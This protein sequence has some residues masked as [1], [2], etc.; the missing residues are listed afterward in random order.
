MTE[1]TQAQKEAGNYKMGHVKMQGLDIS[2]E[3][4]KGSK[5]KGTSPDGTP[6]ESEMD[7][8]YGYVKRTEGADGDHVDVF[9]GANPDSDRVYVVD[10]K[11]QDGTFDEHKVMLG[12]NDQQSAVDGYHANYDEGWQGMGAVTEMSM[13]E[14]KDWLKTGDT[15]KGLSYQPSTKLPPNF[16][17]PRLKRDNYRGFLDA[18]VNRDLLTTKE[19]NQALVAD[20]ARRGESDPGTGQLKRSQS[21]NPDW[22]KRFNEQD[23]RISVAEARNAVRKALAGEKLG[24]RQSRFVGMLLDEQKEADN[25]KQSADSEANKKAK[26]NSELDDFRLSGSDREADIAT[27]GGQ[28]DLLTT[29]KASTL[30]ELI[31]QRFLDIRNNNDLKRLL[32]EYHNKPVSEIT[33][34]E[35]KEG[36]EAYEREVVLSTREAVDVARKEIT[37]RSDLRK[38]LFEELLDRYNNQPLLNSR[39]STSMANQAYSTPLPLSFLA[40]ELAGIQSGSTVYE[41]TA[42]NGALLVSADSKGVHANE[43]EDFRAESLKKQG[44]N[45]TRYDALEDNIPKHRAF[46]AMI[47][48]PPFGNLPDGPEKFQGYT[49]KKIEQLIAAKALESI[50][51]DG[52]ASIIIGSN[53]KPGVI[54]AGDRVFFNWLYSHYNVIDHFE[55]DGK[56]YNRQGAGWPVTIITVNGRSESETLAPDSGSIDRLDDWRE[57]YDHVQRVLDSNEFKPVE[58]GQGSAEPVVIEPG[59]GSKLPGQAGSKDRSTGAASERKPEKQSGSNSG[60]SAGV[61]SVDGRNE[62]GGDRG[63]AGAER[64]DTAADQPGAISERKPTQSEDAGSGRAERSNDTGKPSANR[65][66]KPVSSGSS[67][68][69]AYSPSS[70][71]FNENVLVPV[72]METALKESLADLEQNVGDIDQYVMEKLGYDS[73][74]ELHDAFMG[75]QVDSVA[76]AIYNAEQKSKGIII[77]DQTGVGK[78]RQ[79]AGVIRYALRNNKIP[80]FVTVK[81]N[82]FT[83][84]YNDSLDIGETSLSPFIFNDAGGFVRDRDA[85]GQLFKNTPAKRKAGMESLK[86]GVLP[87]GANALFLTFSQVNK[88]G[89]QREA[90]ES[91]ANEVGDRIVFVMDESHNASGEIESIKKVDGKKQI[92]LTGAGFWQK[93]INDKAVVYL[94]A[95]YAKRPDNMPL[96]YRTDLMDSV[97]KPSDLIEATKAGG[98]ALQTVIAN[99][100]A[101]SGQLWRRERSFDGIEIKTIVNKKEK[102]R[103][104]ELSDRINSGLRSVVDADTLLSSWLEHNNGAGSK[105]VLDYLGVK[106]GTASHLG[107]KV[108]S[109]ADHSPFTSVIHNYVRQMLLALKADWIADEAIK[110]HKAGKKP[111][112]AL[113]ST[114]ESFLKHA[115]E[116]GETKVGE[117]WDGDYRSILIKALHRTKALTVKDDKGDSVRH[118]IPDHIMP[119]VVQRAY[120]E[121]EEYI[122]GLELSDVPIMTI[123]YIRLKLENAGIN[124]SEITGRQYRLDYSQA[125]PVVTKRDSQ[126]VKDRRATIDQFNNGDID[127][128]ILNAAGSTGLSIHASEK[129]AD[130]KTRHMLVAQPMLDI[131]ILMQMLGRINRTGQLVLPEYS[132]MGLDLPAEKRPLAVANRKMRSLN[133]NTSANTDSDT[134]LDAPDILNKYGDQVVRQYL[135]DNAEIARDLNIAAIDSEGLAMKFTGRLALLD[136]KTQEQVYSDIEEEYK[137]LIAYLDSTGQNDLKTDSLDL[138]AKIISSSVAYEGKEPGTLFGGDA[139]LHHVDVKLIGKPPNAKEVMKQIQKGLKGKNPDQ[140]AES[141]YAP[142][143]KAHDRV[144]ADLN[145]EI[146]ESE[147]KLLAIEDEDKKN[148]AQVAVDRLVERRFDL[149][150]AHDNAHLNITDRFKIGSRVRLD[151][152]DDTVNA[153]V[154]GIKSNYKP[155]IGNPFAASKIRVSF[156]TNSTAG[157]ITLP[158]SKL[159]TNSGSSVYMESLQQKPITIESVEDMFSMAA[160]GNKRERRYV[161]TGNLIGGYSKLQGGRVVNF[162]AAN[163]KTYTGILLPRSW[164]KNKEGTAV[165]MQPKVVRDSG[166]VQKYL[167]KIKSDEGLAAIGVFSQPQSVRIIPKDDGY[168]ITVPRKADKTGDS[169]KFDTELHGILGDEFAGRGKLMSVTFK[170]AKLSAVIDRVMQKTTL[171]IPQSGVAQFEKVGG[172]GKRAALK[173][174]DGQTDDPALAYKLPKGESLE[175][176]TKVEE[177]TATE[178]GFSKHGLTYT[179]T[180]TRNGNPVWEIT[181]IAIKNDE[182]IRDLVK[183]VGKAK[184]YRAKKVWS[185][186]DGENLNALEKALNAYEKPLFQFHGATDSLTNTNVDQVE[187]WIAPV[188][189]SW[190]ELAPKVRVL[191]SMKDAPDAVLREAE[192]SLTS[193]QFKAVRYKDTVYLVASAMRDRVDALKSLAHESRAHWGLSLRSDAEY[194]TI[195]ERVNWAARNNGYLKSKRE[196]VL[197]KLEK[198]AQDDSVVAEEI[199]ATVA[200][201]MENGRPVAQLAKNLVTR[202][203]NLVRKVLRKAGFT[204][205]WNVSDIK[206]LLLEHDRWLRSSGKATKESERDID[207]PYFSADED[208][209]S[210]SEIADLLGEDLLSELTEKVKSAKSKPV[211]SESYGS[212]DEVIDSVIAPRKT[213]GSS[214]RQVVGGAIGAI[215][216]RDFSRVTPHVNRFRQEFINQFEALDVY[217]KAQNEGKLF[218]AARSAAK[219][220]AMTKNLDGVMAAIMHKGVIYWDHKAGVPKIKKGSKS[221]HDIF[222]PLGDR[223]LLRLWESW[224]AAQRAKR[225]LEEGK[226]N[227]FTPE[228]IAKIDAEVAKRGLTK[229]FYAVRR[230][231]MGFNRGILNFAEDAGL[232]NPDERE[233]W[234]KDDYV[235]F[236]RVEELRN[237]DGQIAVVDDRGTGN[238]KNGGIQGQSSKIQQLKGGVERI[239]PIESMVANTAHLIDASFKN[240]AMQRTVNMLDG[241]GMR[242]LGPAPM[243][244]SEAQLREYLS[245]I[246]MDY[247]SLPDA[248]K[249]I[250]KSKLEAELYRGKHVVSVKFAGKTQFYHVH[251][252]LLFESIS[253]MGPER[254][255]MLLRLFRW[256]ARVLRASVTANPSFMTANY[257]RDVLSTWMTSSPNE[258]SPIKPLARAV[259]NLATSRTKSDEYWNVLIAGGGSGFYTGFHDD[260]VSYLKDMNKWYPNLLKSSWKTWE[261]FG[262]RW[263]SA[264]RLAAYQAAM[265]AGASEAEAA[266]QALDVLNFSRMGRNKAA[267]VLFQLIPFMNAR[268]QGLDKLFRGAKEHPKAFAIKAS[269]MAGVSLAL[270]SFNLDDED[271]ERVEEFRRDQY[272]YIKAND[273]MWVTIPKPFEVGYLFGTLPERLLES[274]KKENGKEGWESFTRFFWD[275]MNFNPLH[276]QASKPILEDWMN[277]SFFTDRPIIP[278]YMEDWMP[279]MQRDPWTSEAMVKIARSMP[280]AAPDW[281][282]SPK[283]LEHYIKGYLGP[284]AGYGL[285]TA[286]WIAG[287]DAEK[288]EMKLAQTPVVNRFATDAKGRSKFPSEFYEI[289]KDMDAIFGSYRQLLHEGNSE[290]ARSVLAD[291]KESVRYYEQAK[292][293][294]KI[295]REL[296]RQT[297]AIYSDRRMSASEKRRRLDL[298][299]ERRHEVSKQVVELVD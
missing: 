1:P 83:D 166:L 262:A 143:K 277:K 73:E 72:N 204:I 116:N 234:E 90:I 231:W 206:G 217:E 296:N 138:D 103:H 9:L 238:R 139:T 145:K 91:L 63:T 152:G 38:F 85:G 170:Q 188:V 123:D 71:G 19:G 210:D 260:P 89:P 249:D 40:A 2:I 177:S 224:A 247:D 26:A 272:W 153:I 160:S 3:N 74:A 288:P 233:L 242:D 186:Y 216:K 47:T 175:P 284:L 88:A 132:M 179:K 289:K 140:H 60:E 59:N 241:V 158:L 267:K 94:S 266:Y 114:M 251:D 67:Y 257:A 96:Y 174:F 227:L 264:A 76:S 185:I 46:D 45:V 78:G 290:D 182:G 295:L 52:R 77:A 250:W 220:A 106:G 100:L 99:M 127:A 142:L 294:E 150:K 199:I 207:K 65:P 218:D 165:E 147:S 37:N 10:Q 128:L 136:V 112:I 70:S 291:N 33:E 240:I 195:V 230:E 66:R 197:S 270:A 141:V 13:P 50:K 93:V 293:A 28:E 41:P 25:A 125:V 159:V 297:K 110:L 126:E 287:S 248:T 131:N 43:L 34:Q 189:A 115:I 276:T 105:E 235:P 273:D 155:G 239:S 198:S 55:V 21:V 298:I 236:H 92:N 84:M 200:E 191:A 82:L 18:M 121:A 278:Y 16:N 32:A 193:K 122:D 245:R 27:A 243:P 232:I 87:D 173:S 30:D 286:N 129:F 79:A 146:E 269:I 101:R 180:E 102:A 181:G 255:G 211:K 104:A 172:E 15:K 209:L 48:N 157:M 53:K 62:P 215:F 109:H 68:Q 281:M 163:K 176:D 118:P 80:V 184:W 183:R 31:S 51:D 187:E 35:I 149:E 42:G 223:G 229:E 39:T 203:V 161:A 219:A 274:A 156:A 254:V 81:P 107:G 61:G 6:W 271:Y 190:G 212:I 86:S 120:N 237:E 75:L 205:P 214:V 98:E 133:A 285:L 208:L 168:V 292:A 252:D 226:E 8:H 64:L 169:L 196:Q 17:D 222:K 256:P 124:V 164:G 279:E 11:N 154:T 258:I 283:R 265:K 56:L 54:G 134:S 49:I 135:D 57:I 299:D 117:T 228:K 111:V 36:Q 14:F 194:D 246:D 148:S 22:F 130:Q 213:V 20:Q 7:S 4:P 5:R 23:S 201:D 171:Y 282:R 97:D 58:R 280:E 95:T 261:R 192:A 263:E 259:R 275:T 244:L 225:L 119:P 108:Q 69:T 29:N 178:S 268:I 167:K 202:F 151:I 44:F 221:F 162:T 12:F 113:E 137:D 253:A 24:V 144:M